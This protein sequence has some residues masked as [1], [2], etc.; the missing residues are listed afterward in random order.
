MSFNSHLNQSITLANPSGTRDK[1]GQPGYAAA[2]TLR[3]RVQRTNKTIVTKDRDRAP[4]H[5]IIFIGPATEPQ[6]DSQIVYDGTIYR[7]MAIEDVPGKN[8]QTHHYE[9]MAQL[10]SFA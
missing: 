5:A 10:W 4:I 8:G 7:V 9:I 6:T 1:Q 2:V 3:A